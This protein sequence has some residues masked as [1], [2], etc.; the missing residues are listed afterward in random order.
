[1]IVG[2]ATVD[3]TVIFPL[4]GLGEVHLWSVSM[5]ICHQIHIYEE[6][7][8]VLPTFEFEISYKYDLSLYIWTLFIL[9]NSSK[10]LC[11]SLSREQ[12]C[13]SS[14]DWQDIYSTFL[15][16]R[17]TCIMTV[18]PPTHTSAPKSPRLK[19]TTTRAVAIVVKLAEV[20]AVK[21]K[22]KPEKASVRHSPGNMTAE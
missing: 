9:M 15:A 5:E 8:K 18:T 1:M 13:M 14:E 6:D 22:K 4:K 16:Q 2:A 7:P 12:R 20:A 3:L 19:P 21:K 11:L 17:L 10:L